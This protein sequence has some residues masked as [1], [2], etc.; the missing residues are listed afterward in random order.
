M[1]KYGEMDVHS[2]SDKNAFTSSDKF[3]HYIVQ[4]CRGYLSLRLKGSDT[5]TRWNSGDEDFSPESLGLASG[6]ERTKF[7]FNARPLEPLIE[8]FGG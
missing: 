4:Y 3:V 5:L 6:C 7:V 8:V 2:R 1:I